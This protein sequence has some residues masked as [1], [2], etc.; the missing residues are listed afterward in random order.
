MS[1]RTGGSSVAAVRWRRGDSGFPIMLTVSRPPSL[2]LHCS[3][4]Q[5]KQTDQKN[6][7]YL[8]QR[9]KKQ[10]SSTLSFRKSSP[11]PLLINHKP[12]PQTKLE[13]LDA[14][15]NDLESSINNG[16]TID[17]QTYASLLETC[18]R[19]RALD[20][21]V[22]INRLIPPNLLRKNEG[23]SSKLLRLYA[24]C[25][26][27]NGAHEVFD[28]MSRRNVAAFPWN[29]LIAGYAESGQYEDAIALYFQMAEEGVEPDRYTFPRVLKAC[30]GIKSIHIGEAVHRDAIRSGFTKDDFV[31][32]SL[33][34]MYAKCGD[35]V[36][37]RKVFEKIVHKD[38]VS[39]NSMLM[40]YIRH[41][42]LLETL[43]I[44]RE[45]LFQG[46]QPDSISLSSILTGMSSLK[47]ALQVQ[48]W[49]VRREV[50]WN[51][52]I[53][54]SLIV[55]YSNHGMLDKA[56]WIFDNMPE[57]DTVSW[58]SIISA[59]TKSREALLYYEQMVRDGAKPDCITFVSLLSTCAHLGLVKDGERL[60]STMKEKFGI[61]PSMEHYAC[62]VNLYGRAGMVYEAYAIVVERMEIEAGPTVWGALLHACCLHRN[63]EIGEI[64]AEKLF[65]L[66]PDNEHNFELL[67]RIYENAGRLEDVEKVRMMAAERGLDFLH[68]D[69]QK[70]RT[71]NTSY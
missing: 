56:R 47:L 66:E 22:R 50:Q 59:H 1:R 42:L 49:V 18:Y 69:G 10:R 25:G 20:Q 43:D 26:Q 8:S 14:V 31:L 62:V 44:F 71:R 51:L 34:D 28:R 45:M 5:R 39:W 53:A 65:E 58:N 23:L 63:V 55:V 35:I 67:I 32:N 24:S 33:V 37:A 19:L 27:V 41:G 15:I 12:S 38:M 46:F 16:I 13:A 60:F 2:R 40:G 4:S 6:G 11:T 3:S 17:T 7:R 9:H 48:G 21:G 54:N 36:R 57:R 68:S 30:A 61:S 29:S 70:H 52:S 64:A